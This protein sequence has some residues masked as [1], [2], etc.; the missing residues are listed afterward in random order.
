MRLTIEDYRTA[1]ERFWRISITNSW[2]FCLMRD[3][4]WIIG[5]YYFISVFL[6]CYTTIMNEYSFGKFHG[7]AC[8]ASYQMLRE[9]RMK[10]EM[11]LEEFSCPTDH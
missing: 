1:S 3:I 11:V 5:V 4:Y 8:L 7:N 2:L 10:W 9:T 6:H